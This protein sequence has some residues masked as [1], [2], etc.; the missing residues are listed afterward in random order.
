[1]SEK[2]PWY[3][4]VEEQVF[5]RRLIGVAGLRPI[6]YESWVARSYRN[7]LAPIFKL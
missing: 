5:S 7:C 4:V 3:H 1:M 2:Y 6:F